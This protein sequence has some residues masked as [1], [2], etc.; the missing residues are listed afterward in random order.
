LS[1]EV[2]EMQAKQALEKPFHRFVVPS[3]SH[4]WAVTLEYYVDEELD[5]ETANEETKVRELSND[6]FDKD[7]IT[8]KRRK[9]RDHFYY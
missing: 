8:C 9:K 6:S 5:R 4:T 2:K 7:Y 3:E 1:I